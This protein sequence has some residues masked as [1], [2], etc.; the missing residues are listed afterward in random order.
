VPEDCL[1]AVNWIAGHLGDFGP[2]NGR[3]VIGGGSAGANLTANTCMT[4]EES[5]RSL[6]SGALLLYPSVDHYSAEFPSHVERATGGILTTKTLSWFWD[7]Y[8]A[9]ADPESPET[10]GAFPLRSTR[11]SSMPPTLLVTAEFDPLRDEGITFSNKLQAAGVSVEHHHF[12]TADHDFAC[13]EGPNENLS[14]LMGDIA[15]WLDKLD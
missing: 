7:T 10:I 9:G 1:A 3:L 15:D 6:V 5:T 2:S 11:L 12:D 8:L 14:R 4:L 13:S